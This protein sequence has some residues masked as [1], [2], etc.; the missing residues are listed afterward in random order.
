MKTNH[1]AT[2]MPHKS[3]LFSIL[4]LAVAV[5]A[6]PAAAVCPATVTPGF[7]GDL[8]A[9]YPNGDGGGDGGAGGDGGGAGAGAGEGKVLGGLM[10]V[11]RL[12]DG[13]VLGSAVTDSTR[14]LVTIK[15][16]SVDGPVLLTLT[17]R[18]GATYYDEGMGRPLQFDATRTLHALVDRFDENIGVSALTEGAYRY[19]LNNIL[20][21]AADVRAGR[22]P[23][24]T[25]ATAAQ[26]RT[27]TAAQIQQ[28]NGIVLAELNAKLLASYKLTSV[29]SLPT[30]LDQNSPTSVISTNRYGL[31]AAVTGGISAMAKATQPASTVPGLDA[32]E[33]LANDLSDGRLD[34]FALDG[35]PAACSRAL[36]TYDAP[37][38]PVAL[39]VGVNSIAQ[40]FGATTAFA[41]GAG[42]AELT[43][44]GVP[45]FLCLSATGDTATL[46][47]DG[48][49]TVLRNSCDS[50]ATS[51]T[52]NNFATRVK[53]LEGSGGD[54]TYPNRGYLVKDDGSLWGWG[55]TNC[56]VL[57]N[58]ATAVGYL[59]E[60]TQI[61]GVQNVTSIASGVFFTLARDSTGAAYTWGVNYNGT[62]GLGGNAPGA[63]Q[64]NVANQAP[65]FNVAPAVLRPTLIPGLTNVVSVAADLVT[66]YAI[67]VDGNLYQW[68]LIPLR[69]NFAD[70]TPGYVGDY[71]DQF[72]PSRVTGL[73][74]ISGIAISYYMKM[75][76]AADGTVRGFGPNIGGN[77]GS[78]TTTP[79]ITPAQVPGL[80]NVVEIAA[81]VTS[82]FVA[83]LQDGSIR[84]W[85]GCCTTVSGVIDPWMVRTPT[86]PVPGNTLFYTNSRG[87]YSGTLPP[88]R[89]VKGNGGKVI[90]YGTDGSIY[91]FPKSKSEIV[92]VLAVEAASTGSAL[93]KSG[94]W[95][96][97]AE[98]GRG[99][100][101]EFSGG[102]LFMAG[103][104]YDAS[105]RATWAIS[106][107]AMSQDG[108]RYTGS[109][110]SYANGQSLTGTYRAPSAPISL[111]TISL[112]F[113]DAT[114]G[115]IGTTV[116]IERFPFGPNG[117]N[118][119]P[120][121]GVPESG[122]WWNAAETGRGYFIEFQGDTAFIAGYMYDTSGNPLWY[123]SG[124]AIANAQTYQGNWTQY[125]NGQTLNGPY[126]PAT[127][128]NANV[129]ALGITF[130]NATNGTL[131][132]P[133]G[134]QIQI[135][136]F[137]F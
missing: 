124:S 35:K 100:S 26:L 106:G 5:I 37:R 39:Q 62:L 34:G 11:T 87:I 98:S 111:G 55:S 47:K 107:G 45:Q 71:T 109:L 127:L 101:L 81:S 75:A 21:N 134:R 121:P 74:A 114:H 94:W 48:T 83:L 113:T 110:L 72:F 102:N 8:N 136:R 60:P 117:I 27:L 79:V 65:P 118:S 20:A 97:P 31:A 44:V 53:L 104:F 36:V 61:T 99:Y 40:R 120:L 80:S 10:T 129:G 49:V 70:T 30:P 1:K 24:Q 86:A 15:P 90:L 67:D 23:L 58:G 68:G 132:L 29:R 32:G 92:F 77:F 54:A 76:V 46:L 103:Y 56:G 22:L 12:S 25:S 43:S 59:T 18:A 89:H 135:T 14:G 93:P 33:Q 69:Y 112:N 19:A 42:V 105:G 57:G 128:V 82:P 131:T 64:C 88:I 96:N 126:R 28:A 3:V 52:L 51:T 85:G 115:M 2:R 13:A 41:S 9:V 116:P 91:L 66:A 63:V 108:L 122:W 137:R 17:G 133:N 84:Y 38:L 95:W 7:A 125:A 119:T 16:C 73:P 123:I 4:A 78:G 130:Q 6:Q 50:G